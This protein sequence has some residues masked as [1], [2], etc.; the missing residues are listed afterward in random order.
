MAALDLLAADAPEQRAWTERF[1]VGVD[2]I[3]LRY[4]DMYRFAERLSAEGRL[5]PETLPLLRAVDAHLAAMTADGR[6]PDLWT[7]EALA[8]QPAWERARI[9]ARRALAAETAQGP[10][11]AHP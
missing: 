8:M 11:A 10:P 9:L 5:R 2:E 6:A 7:R 3:A 1:G 4:D